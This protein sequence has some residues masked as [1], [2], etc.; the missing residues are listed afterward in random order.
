MSP[1]SWFDEL[2]MS[3]RCAAQTKR[4]VDG[5]EGDGGGLSDKDIETL[6]DPESHALLTKRSIE[7]ARS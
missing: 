7:G 3:E 4:R 5:F 1:R 6:R 2:T